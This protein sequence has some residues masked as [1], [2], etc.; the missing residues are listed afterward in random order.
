[1]GSW[2]PILFRPIAGLGLNRPCMIHRP[3]NKILRTFGAFK[4]EKD[5]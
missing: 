4:G 5:S 2:D 1:M 3:G